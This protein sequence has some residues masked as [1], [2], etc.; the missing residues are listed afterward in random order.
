MFVFLLTMKTSKLTCERM[1][2]HGLNLNTQSDSQ[3]DSLSQSNFASI[4][5]GNIKCYGLSAMP[6]RIE[7]YQ[8]S[9]VEYSKVWVSSEKYPKLQTQY[10]FGL[11]I[12]L[13]FVLW[14]W[15]QIYDLI[16]YGI[17]KLWPNEIKK[18]MVII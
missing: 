11:I 5:W 18:E 12:T 7:F 1:G 16:F 4:K 17:I 8:Q 3:W 15:D 13:I 14:V 6:Q 9:V 2:G 10:F